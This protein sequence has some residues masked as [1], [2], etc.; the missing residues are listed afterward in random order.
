M[1]TKNLKTLIKL[2][3]D[4]TLSHLSYEDETMSVTLEKGTSLP[5]AAP[6][7]VVVSTPS[8][9]SSEAVEPPLL[10]AVRSPLVGIFYASPSPDQPAFVA[11]GDSVK[12][13]Q[14][15]CIIEAMKVMN[16]ISAPADGVVKDILIKNGEMVMYDQPLLVIA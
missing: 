9:A 2:L 10:N 12:K 6:S 13:G 7:P 4:S 1:N 16:E 3:E 8:V 5:T 14:T 15:L 11:V